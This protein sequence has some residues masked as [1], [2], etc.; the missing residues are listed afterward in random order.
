MNSLT[1]I[2]VGRASI[3]NPT[4]PKTVRQSY[5]AC[6][7]F[8]P[9]ETFL[10]LSIPK[11]KISRH[12]QTLHSLSSNHPKRS[13]ARIISLQNPLKSRTR[14]TWLPSA[15]LVCRLQA[16]LQLSGH[17]QTP[18]LDRPTALNYQVRGLN[19]FHP[20]LFRLGYFDS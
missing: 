17:L 3:E 19:F 7:N 14:F 4:F 8:L 5:R 6:L 16:K 10:L 1:V 15:T 11:T 12:I 2:S 13:T 9:Q 18:A 20:L